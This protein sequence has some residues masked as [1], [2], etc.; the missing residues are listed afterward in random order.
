MED[1]E[2]RKTRKRNYAKTEKQKEYRRNYMREWR[3]NNREKYNAWAKEYNK[4]NGHKWVTHSKEWQRT[5]LLKRQYNLTDE[6]FIL[7]LEKQ[8]NKCYICGKENLIDSKRLH[9]DHDHTTGK[10]RGLLCSRCNGALG[11]YELYAEQINM[12]LNKMW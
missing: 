4:E 5:Y 6:D 2:K 11:W 12:Y 7:L 9:V 3:K 8:N 1:I 10:V